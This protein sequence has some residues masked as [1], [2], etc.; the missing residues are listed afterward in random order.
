M[1]SE[2]GDEEEKERRARNRKHYYEANRDRIR[3]R[4]K[5]YYALNKEAHKWRSQ[6]WRGRNPERVRQM[7]KDWKERNP[8]KVKVIRE[9]YYQTNRERL[10][11]NIRSRLDPYRGPGYTLR[12]TGFKELA[13]HVVERAGGKCE[14][15]G[16][17]GT[18]GER[19]KGMLLAHYTDFNPTNN[20][21]E[22]IEVICLSCHMT[23]HHSL[24]EI[25]QALGGR[26]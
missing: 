23:I 17:T 24:E 2:A 4:Q 13:D 14:R 1:T 19:G 5:E 7:N 15:C 10:I 11:Q 8:E 25:N 18:P 12:R 26:T 21:P 6:E 3:Q 20:V 22:N 16:V 9:R